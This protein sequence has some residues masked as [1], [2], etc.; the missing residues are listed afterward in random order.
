MEAAK[1]ADRSIRRDGTSEESRHEWPG[2][3]KLPWIDAD[4]LVPA[5]TRAVVVA[6]I[7]MTRS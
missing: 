5:G 4:A 2:L 1:S 6:P 7:R 3:A